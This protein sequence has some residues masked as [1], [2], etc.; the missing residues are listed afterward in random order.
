MRAR[1]KTATVVAGF[2][3]LASTLIPWI[4]RSNDGILIYADSPDALDHV[5]KGVEFRNLKRFEF[6][7]HVT[8]GKTGQI[9]HIPNNTIVMIREYPNVVGGTVRSAEEIQKIKILAAEFREMAQRFPRASQQLIAESD[10]LGGV[11]QMIDQGMVLINGQWKTVKEVEAQ[12]AEEGKR[13]FF[14]RLDSGETVTYRNVKIIEI[15]GD[16]VRISHNDGY[17]TVPKAK[18]PKFILGPEPPKKTEEI[19]S[20]MEGERPGETRIFGG[21]EM[22]W[23][24]P[25]EFTMGAAALDD[26]GRFEDE[27][28]YSASI[29][30]GFWLA[31]TE[32]TQDQ[33]GLVMGNHASRFEGGDRPVERVSWNEA[34]K[35]IEKMNE[36]HP[37]ESGWGWSLPTEVQWEYAATGGG[38]QDGELRTNSQNWHENNSSG[39][40]RPV[41]QGRANPWSLVDM[42]GNV[43]EW[44]ADV[45]HRSP[46]A[47]I[48]S[49][50]P[51]AAGALRV[52]RGGSW[53]S[54]QGDCRSTYRDWARPTVKSPEIGFRAALAP[55]E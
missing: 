50:D 2:F 36:E 3:G 18:I 15:I 37:P 53:S 32:T 44:C 19:L 13:T 24:P 8:D 1:Y 35:W 30:R 47:G 23:C 12:E 41:T 21:V 46:S 52:V 4:A 40:T 55:R 34:A 9:I 45:Y 7:T 11:I 26:D 54:R 33:W 14:I 27:K 5:A 28:P 29:R 48:R 25:G 6:V 22:V 51:G 16:E 49:P 17:S 31:K 38:G 42:L 20:T 10:R 39:R 43:A